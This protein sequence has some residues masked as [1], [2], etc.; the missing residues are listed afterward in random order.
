MS[1]HAVIAGGSIGGLFAAAMLRR[2]GWTVD[3]FERSDVELSGRGAG[4][5]THAELLDAL[6]FCGAGTKDLG[7]RVEKR[8]AFDFDGNPV[9]QIDFPQIVTSWDRVHTLLRRIIPDNQHHLDRQITGYRQ[10][11]N[12]VTVSFSDGG[13]LEADILVGADGFRSSVRGQMHPKV[14]P[15]F[16]GYVVWRALANESDIPDPIHKRVFDKFGFYLPAG[17]QIIGY[18]IAGPDN[19]L[20]PGHRRY[21]FV[22]Y[23]A[24]GGDKLTDMLTDANGRTHTMSIPPPLIREDVLSDMYARARATL[25]RPF[26]EMLDQ[27]DRPFFT[28]IY[29]HVS[30]S[31]NDGRVALC[32]DAAIVARPHVGMGVTKAACDARVLAE[33]LDTYASAPEALAAYSD[34]RRR[35]GHNAFARSRKLGSYIFGDAGKVINKDGRNNPNIETIMRD[36]AVTTV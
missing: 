20:R 36:T 12:G 34:D 23:T 9:R 11:E 33:M 21:N 18:P 29:D 6:T 1:R 19:D 5:V 13:N 17:N 15:V 8:V 7:V 14:N 16:S 26:V 35:K 3:V 28:P 25:S 24:V 30:P 22:W 4:I 27:S 31:L 32:G 2:S 10:D